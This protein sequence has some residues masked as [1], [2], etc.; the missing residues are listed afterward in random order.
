[1]IY[2][3]I[4]VSVFSSLTSIISFWRVCVL[5]TGVYLFRSLGIVVKRSLLGNGHTIRGYW[6]SRRT[7]ELNGMATPLSAPTVHRR[8]LRFKCDKKGGESSG[9]RKKGGWME[10][11]LRPAHGFQ[12]QLKPGQ[13]AG[14]RGSQLPLTNGSHHSV[15]KTPFAFK[16][17][18]NPAITAFNE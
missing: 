15:Q 10:A 4:S 6:C 14:V 18:H 13:V 12:F 1:M 3:F 11:L 8:P 9:S 16:E 7:Q 17:T 5:C 2:E